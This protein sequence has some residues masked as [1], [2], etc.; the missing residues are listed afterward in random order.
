[1]F[2]EKFEFLLG[3]FEALRGTRTQTLP[4]AGLLPQFEIVPAQTIPFG[5]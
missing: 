4:I 1:M 3:F 2:A 5:T